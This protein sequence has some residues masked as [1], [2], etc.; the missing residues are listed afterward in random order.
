M[1]GA[2]LV[3]STHDRASLLRFCVGAVPAILVTLFAGI[4][5][6]VALFFDRERRMYALEFA[7]RCVELA[8]VLVGVSSSRGPSRRPHS[9]AI[10]T[11]RTRDADEQHVASD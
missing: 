10:I 1:V 9:G 8:A 11:N 5:G 7:D 3:V 6:L 2:P 4:V